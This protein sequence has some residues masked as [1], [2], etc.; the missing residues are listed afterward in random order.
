MAKRR[1]IQSV[2]ISGV[3]ALAFSV[4]SLAADLKSPIS[5]ENALVLPKRRGNPRLITAY[6]W[7]TDRLG[8]SGE[9]LP[10]ASKLN[11]SVSWADLISAQEVAGR[12]DTGKQAS[13]AALIA[14]N[15]LEAE[16]TGPGETTGVVTTSARVLAPALAFGLTER[17]TLAFALPVVTM[18][19]SASTGFTPNSTGQRFVDSASLDGSPAA[20]QDAVEKL[21]DPV[22][23]KLTRLGYEPIQSKSFT[24]VGD[25]QMISKVSLYHGD[26]QDFAIRNTVSFPTGR[27][28]N[29]DK[30]LDVPTGDGRIGLGAQFIYDQRL[31]WDFAVTSN[32]GTT[33]LLPRDLERRLPVSADDSL[34]RDKE[35]LTERARGIFQIGGGVQ[36]LFP[37][38]GVT[39]GMGYHFQYQTAS[40]FKDG[41]NSDPGRYRLLEDLWP[42]QAIHSLLLSAG[43]STVD[44]FKQKRFFYPMQV[45][46][47][48]AKP[49]SGRNV[50][51]SDVFTGE[52]VLFF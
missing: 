36:H 4:V 49:L 30:A 48:F 42:Q 14:K 50:A 12:P 31:P 13:L 5:L 19:I 3:S 28:P 40:S 10:L 32:L 52:L 45:N 51:L 15:G 11:K 2:A 33:V 25:L 47:N 34:S 22:N 37:R 23:Q 44:F 29:A 26:N 7:I 27:A 8:D 46:F 35:L 24:A 21:R 18:D 9:T 17:W 6:T 16:A 43:F 38:L 1:I 20:G 39:L 41:G